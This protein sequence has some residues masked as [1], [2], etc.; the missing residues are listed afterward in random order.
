MRYLIVGNSAAGLSAARSIRR[1]DKDGEITLFSDEPYPYYPRL[2]LTYFIGGKLKKWQLFEEGRNIYHNCSLH[3][4]LDDPIIEVSWKDRTIRSR[5]GR[6][7]PF[8]RL[9]IA[10]GAVAACPDLPGRT[11]PGVF[12]LRTLNDGEDILERI[13]P[14][15]A[16]IILGGGL[17]G[18]QT[19]QA[20]AWQGMKTLVLVG[21]SRL[22][23]RNLDEKGAFLLRKNAEK[24]GID[25]LINSEVRGIEKGQGGS[26]WVLRERGEALKGELVVLAK[27]VRPSTRL[28][29]KEEIG[30]HGGARVNERMETSRPGV[31]AAGD[32][33]E[34]LDQAHRKPRINPVWPNA[35]EQGRMAGLNMAGAEAQYRGTI[36]MNVTELFGVR[37]ASLGRL[38]PEEGDRE[39]VF[40]SPEGRVYRKF[41]VAGDRIEGAV[42][43]GDLWDCGILQRLIRN[44]VPVGSGVLKKMMICSP[45]LANDICGN[46]RS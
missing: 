31:F 13:R 21:S 22:L 12:S 44:G 41:V 37:V 4:R 18:L 42:L 43:I 17:V 38:E 3:T 39:L 1:R 19:A 2:L 11:L 29:D 26:L 40:I 23:S 20:L 24:S 7:F 35:V 32:V 45:G 33:V 28:L 34:F 36:G 9:L 5:S 16:A 30:V 14:G 25:V 6:L 27:G 15:G 8:D 46:L 10:T